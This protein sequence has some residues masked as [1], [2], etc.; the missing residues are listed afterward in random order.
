MTSTHDLSGLPV[1]TFDDKAVIF[2]HGEPADVAYLLVAGKINIMVPNTAGELIAV[3]NC[4]PG[5]IFGEMALIT[6]GSRT[7]FAIAD[8]ACTC[9][10]INRQALARELAKAD[11]FIRFWINYMTGRLVDTSQ[12]A[13]R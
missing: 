8:G 4:S 5:Q 6:G 13:Q 10:A 11:P 7:A 12:R 3:A 1:S 9:V 2:M